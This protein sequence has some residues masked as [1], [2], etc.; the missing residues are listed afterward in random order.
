[1]KF[2]ML[3]FILF[4]LNS[5][6]LIRLLNTSKEENEDIEKIQKFLSKHNFTYDFIFENTDSTAYLLKDPKYRINNDSIKYSYIQLR[7]YDSKGDLYTG[8]SQCM[9][10][11][12]KKFFLDSFPP[13]K[14]L[15]PFL[16]NNLKFI[17][18]LDL[19]NISEQTKKQVIEFSNSYD[20][21]FVVYWTIWTN[22][23]SKHVLR[24][25]SKIKRSYP[26]K[27]CIIFINTAKEKSAYNH[28]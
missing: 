11:F 3:L 10:N 16:N 1:M 14:N 4:P 9:G 25:V 19:I 28:K 22:Y 26:S 2:V 21:T 13:S 20:Y 5:C 27:V 12:N 18:E 15:Y 23:F 6:N 17:N 7:I 24:E 8:L